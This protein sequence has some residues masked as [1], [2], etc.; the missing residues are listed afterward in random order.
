MKILSF[1]LLLCVSLWAETSV[2][3]GQQKVISKEL[4]QNIAPSDEST[5][6]EKNTYETFVARSTLVLTSEEYAQNFYIGEV[7]SI[8]LYAKTLEDTEF[9]FNIS[10]I[11]NESLNFLNPKSPFE[12]ISN[13]TYKNTLWFEAKDANAN[14]EEIIVEMLRNEQVFQKASLKINPIRFHSPKKDNIFSHIVAS[15]LEVKQVKT[16][17]FDEKNVIMMLELNATN[18]NLKGFFVN[19][20]QKQG[21]ENY[22]GDFNV[23]KAFYYAIFPANKD[24]FEFSYFNKEDKKLESFDIKLQI[25]DDEISTQS[26]LN[27]TNKDFNAYK[28]YALWALA[29]ILALFFVFK[30]NYFILAFALLSFA[31]SFLVDTN[32]HN[33]L[34]KAN[35]RIKILPT[36]PSTYF[37][38]TSTQEEVEILGKRENYIKILLR[39]GKIGWA[40]EVD[41]LKN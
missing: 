33:G 25:S 27:P 14:L 4:Y 9:D 24:H 5:N 11:K 34:L 17:Y 10:L 18:A 21:I 35:A 23:S 31:L 13:D 7:F 15:S 41:L 39:N 2:F 19:G 3:D 6:Y 30:R 26:D 8:E 29:F 40:N 28:Q 12:K 32:T 22:K 37:Y 16:S 38:T 20:V 1:L 36:E